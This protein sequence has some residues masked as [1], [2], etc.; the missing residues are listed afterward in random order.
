MAN[1]EDLHKADNLL[2]GLR[3]KPIRQSL[4]CLLFGCQVYRNAR[5]RDCFFRTCVT[6]VTAPSWP[7]FDLMRGTTL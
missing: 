5:F 1:D 3:L 6:V 7:F 4:A 2:P